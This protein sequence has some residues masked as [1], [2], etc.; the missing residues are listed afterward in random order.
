MASHVSHTTNVRLVLKALPIFFCS[1]QKNP[2]LITS[3]FCFEISRRFYIK[4]RRRKVL[5]TSPWKVL[6]FVHPNDMT[7]ITHAGTTL[8]QTPKRLLYAAR[9]QRHLTVLN[10]WS[11]CHSWK[12]FSKFEMFVTFASLPSAETMRFSQ[13]RMRKQVCVA[14]SPQVH[15][16]L[17]FQHLHSD[18]G[19]CNTGVCHVAMIAVAD[20]NRDM[21]LL[22]QQ[23]FG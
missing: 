12:L 5:S 21:G 8:G 10:I 2:K 15:S 18:F 13:C 3:R 14:V 7:C 23:M 22:T 17:P 19:D 11:C 20:S 16:D 6:C 4:F 1:P 9:E